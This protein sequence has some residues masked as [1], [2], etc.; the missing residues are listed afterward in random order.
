MSN[1]SSTTSNLAALLRAVSNEDLEGWTLHQLHQ[2]QELAHQ[3]AEALW[4]MSRLYPNNA[5]FFRAAADF[6]DGPEK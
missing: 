1:Q 3:H 4:D 6:L 5:P 2:M